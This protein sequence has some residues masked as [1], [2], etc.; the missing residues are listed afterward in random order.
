M[1]PSRRRCARIVLVTLALLTSGLAGRPAWTYEEQIQSEAKRLARKIS[2]ARLGAVAVVDFRDLDGNVTE[3]G[4]FLAEELSGELAS[5]PRGFRVIDRSNLKSL[6]QEHKLASSGLF[7]PKT[8][9]ELG[10]IAGAN[11]L[12]TGT[13]TRL[14]TKVRLRIN[15]LDVETAEVLISSDRDIPETDEIKALLRREIEPPYLESSARSDRAVAQSHGIQFE[16]Q[17]CVRKRGRVQCYFLATSL[18]HERDLTLTLT[19]RAIDGAGSDYPAYAVQIGYK[20][21]QPATN[22]LFPGAPLQMSVTFSGVPTRLPSL[23]MIVLDCNDFTA[24]FQGAR[25]VH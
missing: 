14:D 2:A 7:D 15:V 22:H 18:D 3:L 5:A 19:S 21:N 20:K 23:K 9:R 8:I 4:R 10:K 1:I 17:K 16:F 24:Q 12:V 6:L 25:I 11:A 13:L